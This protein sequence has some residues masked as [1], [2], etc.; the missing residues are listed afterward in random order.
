[1]PV[2]IIGAVHTPPQPFIV[3]VKMEQLLNEYTLKANEE[4]RKLMKFI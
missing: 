3:P 4:L 1:M 2:M